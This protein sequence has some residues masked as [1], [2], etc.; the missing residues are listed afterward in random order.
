M[1]RRFVVI[2]FLMVTVGLLF[3]YGPAASRLFAQSS[4]RNRLREI[5]NA[6]ASGRSEDG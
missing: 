6:R 4:Q 1:K 5:R 2:C 3:G